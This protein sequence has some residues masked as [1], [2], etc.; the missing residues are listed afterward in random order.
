MA[1]ELRISVLGLKSLPSA[2]CFLS[3]SRQGWCLLEGTSTSYGHL[4]S[5]EGTT[6]AVAHASQES[7]CRRI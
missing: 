6:E 7:H 3:Y 5:L 1:G 2:L 4:E